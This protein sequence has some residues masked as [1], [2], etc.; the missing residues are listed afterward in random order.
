MQKILVKIHNAKQTIAEAVVVTKDG[1]PTTIKASKRVNYELIDEST[2]H[3]PHHIIT[4]RVGQD[5]HVSFEENGQESDLIIEGFYDAGETALVGLAEDG[6]YYYYVPDTGNIA[7]YVT[8][9]MVG[10]VEGQALGGTAYPTP[11]WIGASDGVAGFVP[12]LVGLAGIGAVI[13]LTRDKKSTPADTTAPEAPVVTATDTKVTVTPASDA[14]SNTITYKDHTGQDVT[15]TFTKDPNTGKWTDGDTTDNISIDETTG[16]VSIPVINVADKTSVV[17]TTKDGAG[18]S[19][20]GNATTLDI[21][22]SK[23]VLTAENH[24]DVII[25]LPQD[26]DV[27][28]KVIVTIPHEDGT[29]STVTL[30]KTDTGWTSDNPVVTLTA[31]TNTATI[32]EPDVKNGGTVTA[33]AT[34]AD[35]KVDVDDLV[36]VIAK[37]SVPE[38]AIAAN[39]DGSVTINLVDRKNPNASPDEVSGEYTDP[40]GNLQ[41]FVVKKDPATNQY[42]QDPANI[43]DKVTVDPATGTVTIA[44]GEVGSGKEAKASQTFGNDVSSFATTTVLSASL[45]PKPTVTALEDGSATIESSTPE[46]TELTASYKDETGTE[47]TVTAIKDPSTGKWAQDPANVNNK[48]TIDEST[49]KITIPA[50]EVKDGSL[51]TGTQTVPTSPQKGEDKAVVNNATG[52]HPVVP[53]PDVTN[54]NDG[55]VS[56]TPTTNDTPV[57]NATSATATYTDEA[58]NPQTIT[59]TKG[60][61]GTWTKDPAN[62]NDKVTVDPV[63]GTITIPADEVKDGSIVTATQS[64]PIGDSIASNVAKDGIPEPEVKANDNGSV[65]ITPAKDATSLTIEFNDEDN[66]LNPVK[67]EKQGNE[68]VS[69]NPSV[70]VDKDTGV[71][72]IPADKLKD[73]SEVVA[74]QTTPQGVSGDATDRVKAFDHTDKPTI[75]TEDGDKPVTVKPG[76][77][78]SKVTVDYTDE[79]GNPQTITVTKDPATNTW[80]AT[81]SNGNPISTSPTTDDKT[82]Y[83]DPTTGEVTLPKDSVDNSQPVTVVGEKEGADKTTV[84]TS[85]DQTPPAKPTLT[86]NND[87]SVS[88]TPPTDADVKE[89]TVSV[90]DPETNTPK[91][92]T[93]TKN[94][95]G[96]WT[97][98]DPAIVPSIPAGQTSS[99][100]PA[101]KVKDGSPVVATA[102]D[103][104]GN[105]TDPVTTTAGTGGDPKI[106]PAVI[107]PNNDGSVTVTP[108]GDNT[109]LTITYIDETSSVRGAEGKVGEKVTFTDSTP[110][111]QK[112]ENEPS[113]YE[114]TIEQNK[115]VTLNL[116]KDG[117]TWKPANGATLPDGV[118]IKDG[119][120]EF[121]PNSIMGTTDIKVVAENARGQTDTQTD[122][123]KLDT[124]TDTPK[125]YLE[126][127]SSMSDSE[128]QWLTTGA[129]EASEGVTDDHVVI[130]PEQ[131]EGK[132]HPNY[133][134]E[135]TS[136]ATGQLVTIN[137][138]M[139]NETWFVVR[140]DGSRDTI[141]SG[142]MKTAGWRIYHDTIVLPESIS[143]DMMAGQPAR[144]WTVDPTKGGKWQLH[145][146]WTP[147][148]QLKLQLETDSAGAG[149]TGTTSDKVSNVSTVNILGNGGQAWEYRLDGGAWQDGAG[150]NLT[151][152]EPTNGE[153][154]TYQVE[155]RLKDQTDV[156]TQDS[157]T[158]DKVATLDNVSFDKKGTSLIVSGHAEA[159][160]LVTV[161][162]TQGTAGADGKFSFELPNIDATSQK[163]DITVSVVDIAGNT[164]SQ[165]YEVRQ[166]PNI[167]RRHIDEL[168]NELDDKANV[169]IV[170]E[171]GALGDTGGTALSSWQAP[172]NFGAGDD[173]LL[174][175]G[176]VQY[177]NTR[178]NMGTGNDTFRVKSY[179]RQ[180]AQLD[181]GEGD[182]FVKFSDKD[183]GTGRDLY[184]NN[185]SVADN[186]TVI[187]LGAGNDRMET[188]GA[189]GNGAM[190]HG[191]DGFDTLTFT[192]YNVRQNG[193]NF[194]GIE[195]IDLT[196][197]LRLPDQP[198]S[199]SNHS[200]NR[201]DLTADHVRAN[202]DTPMEGLTYSALIID[203]NAGDT[204]DLGDNGG[205]ANAPRL[206]DFVQVNSLPTGD[207]ILD[208]YR[209]Y[210]V[211]NDMETLVLINQAITVL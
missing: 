165:D 85:P 145:D 130:N 73:G 16:V 209:A 77:D 13:G 106:D 48:V 168:N 139:E 210:M 59:V 44:A 125:V 17:A 167:Y 3:A 196:G 31:G 119:K 128:K 126:K 202:A 29:S 132:A 150:T 42:Q 12:W 157:F 88:V 152:P 5:L 22:P 162:G 2:G 87:G 76:E 47:K 14:I 160:S 192:E 180:G 6:Q 55:S 43:N 32:K 81:D 181:M 100:I 146:T 124:P 11:W 187:N 71:V 57:K 91:E 178:I 116:V 62:T 149:T 163:Q 207:A 60:E 144:L 138:V 172:L 18:N 61:D 65:T 96:S 154:Q 140:E 33:V 58:G 98:D 99:T 70:Q 117:D 112:G 161:R 19:S 111:G 83:V 34:T 204:V 90:T 143:N 175:A 38:P 189:I 194:T 45:A 123:A 15:K 197:S 72:T 68:W 170:G 129:G 151:L 97:S 64:T 79:T 127:V 84:T 177:A 174:T 211:G 24:G 141:G 103:Q 56:I 4:K 95:D 200:N 156:T 120:I 134:L 94:D 115:E 173:A 63:T 27:G 186:G 109:K 183:L 153:K 21:P 52:T 182:D 131:H 93:L 206:G 46:A 205:T 179:M 176:A 41:V 199:T 122:T 142:E 201:L 104:A 148:L 171:K 20:Q 9:L 113:S 114:V 89:V 54:N 69:T 8:E 185:I 136:V 86:A 50:D 155:A 26:A 101:D 82:P 37:D 108:G 193:G 53:S 78:N 25:G 40:N 203:G 28:D 133:T 184:I 164:I 23:P 188:G 118:S 36:S 137:M 147:A 121:A 92:V 102:E 30:T 67:V 191:G 158:Y 107:T 80:T 135:Y 10:D 75:T 190:L 105:K 169:I 7:D 198:P 195:K 74:N 66:A 110:T 35:G 39:T 1:T 51:V 159:G 208:G 166:L 49:G